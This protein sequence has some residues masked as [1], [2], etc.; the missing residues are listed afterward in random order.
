LK[1]EVRQNKTSVAQLGKDHRGARRWPCGE[2]SIKV[3]AREDEGRVWVEIAAVLAA[4]VVVSSVLFIYYNPDYSWSSSI[5]DHDGDGYAD[6][7]DAFPNDLTE[8]NDTDADGY[9][10]NCD[11]F[12]S[13]PHEWNDSDGDGVGDNGDAFPNDPT[14]WQDTDGDG[15]GDNQSGTSPDLFPED[16][17]EWNDT[18][19]DGYGDN[20]DVF[21]DDPSEWNDTDGDGVGDNSDYFPNDPTRADR[22][23][24]M[25]IGDSLSND[26]RE[27]LGGHSW[28][29]YLN[30]KLG[31]DWVVSNRAIGGT[32]A[33]SWLE[34]LFVDA[35]EAVHPDIVIMMLGVN[36]IHGDY[37]DVETEATLQ[38]LSEMIVGYGVYLYW[39]TILPAGMLDRYPGA[40]GEL[41]E[42]YRV[43]VSD[44][45]RGQSGSG[46]EVM[47]FVSDFEAFDGS[48]DLK[49]EYSD[50]LLHLSEVG[51][52]KYADCVFDVMQ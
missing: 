45:I 46:F 4:T 18:D 50:D 16:P 43:N 13:D 22:L 39:S 33:A 9:G 2:M 21:P 47:D 52:Q 49:V 28:P 23:V 10:D 38:L 35:Y 51:S 17:S 26:V 32:S 42:S 24:V 1:N 12:P 20:E 34:S 40:L 11:R 7:S 48:D 19:L 25:C 41:R 15:Y 6:G 36:D 27:N 29:Y 31:S 44:W 14:Q 30:Q 5:R 37:T 8:W 3:A